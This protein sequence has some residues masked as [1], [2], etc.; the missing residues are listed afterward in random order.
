MSL[1]PYQEEAKR[2]ICDKWAEGCRA[3]LYTLPTGGGKTRIMAQIVSEHKGSACVI[4]HRQELVAQIS[5][6][7]ARSGVRHRI[8]GPTSVVKLAVRI[9]MDEIGKSFYDPSSHIAVAGVDTLIRRDDPMK[10]VTLWLMDEA[11]HVLRENKWGK[12]VKKF[13]HARG[14]GVTATPMRTDG[15]GLGAHADGFFDAIIEGPGMRDLIGEG[16]LTEYRVF[17][18]PSDLDMTGVRLSNNGDYARDG[19]VKAVGKS[20]IL[21][22]IVT[23][24]LKIAGG[25]LG[26]TF[27]TDVKTAHQIAEQYS[28]AGVPAAA[29]SAETPDVQRVETIQKFKKKELLQLV[30]V[31]LFGEGFD[32]PAI[33]SVS[34]ARPTQSYGLY[35]QIFG[36][37]LRP[38]EGKDHALIIDHVGNVMRHGLPDRPREWTL[39]RRE[40]RTRSTDEGALGLRVCTQCTGVYVRELNTCPYCDF[41]HIPSSRSSPDH[42]DGSLC[43]LDAATL[44]TMRSAIDRVDMDREQYRSEL[45]TKRVPHIGQLAHVKRHVARQEAQKELRYALALWGGKNKMQGKSDDEGHKIFFKKFKIDVLSAQ[46]LGEKD[47]LELKERIKNDLG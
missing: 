26:I 10:D 11:H 3:V 35:A 47:A 22:D 32:L 31:D 14:L 43:E 9:H 38:M 37:A 20:H 8:I 2:A 18:P 5:L 30:N 42:V 13:P 21:G 29:L 34:M 45:I 17:A 1:R 15:M 44:A 4:A 27:A 19:M 12:A 39:D 6:A 24:Y 25:K 7:L 40:K 36:R 33:C 41:T 28:A 16:F 46:A 23:H